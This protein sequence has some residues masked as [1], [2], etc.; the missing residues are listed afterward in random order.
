[1]SEEPQMT[2]SRNVLSAVLP[3][4]AGTLFASGAV[5]NSA[6]GISIG[7][8]NSLTPR[9]RDV[10]CRADPHGLSIFNDAPRR[11]PTGWLYDSPCLP[12]LFKDEAASDTDK[13]DFSI[14]AEV[15]ALVT[16]GDENA[17]LFREFA[18]WSDG[19]LLS[20]FR[21]NAERGRDQFSITAGGIGRDD[22]FGTLSFDRWGSYSVKAFFDKIPH[23][24][25]TNARSPYNGIGTGVLRL[26]PELPPGTNEP[27]DVLAAF[28][29]LQPFTLQ[30]DRERMGLLAEHTAIPNWKFF[31]N[32]LNEDRDGTKPF[33]GGL[34]FSFFPIGSLGVG[35]GMELAEPNRYRTQ[36]F[37][38]GAQKFNGVWQMNVTASGSFFRNEVDTLTFDNPWFLNSLAPPPTGPYVATR[39]RTDLYPDNDSYRIKAEASRAIPW[40]GQFT[41]SVSRG[42]MRQDDAL[43]PFT[44]SSGIGGTAPQ[45]INFDLWNT[46]DALPRRSAEARIATTTAQARLRFSPS[47]PL[48]ISI[49]YRFYDE[50]NKTP[51]FEARNAL[52]GEYGMILMDGVQGSAVPFE[53]PVF[54]PGVPGDPAFHY[55]SIPF[56]TQRQTLETS[57]DY[58]LGRH[59]RASLT[60]T[61][62]QID[63]KF[64]EVA[65]T[66]E[67]RI[68]L[69]WSYRGWE[70]A[71][72]R[73]EGQYASRDGNGY[74]PDPY[75][76]FYSSSLPGATP[77]SPLGFT[78]HALA[79][80][81]KKDV[82]DLRRTK[83]ES[84]LNLM[85][86]DRTDGFLSVQYQEDEYPDSSAGLTGERVTAA[87]AEVNFTPGASFSYF[88][89]ASWQ[90][91]KTSQATINDAGVGLGP[92]PNPGGP[93]FPLENAWSAASEDEDRTVGAGATRSVGPVDLRLN[94]SY[95]NTKTAIDYAYA[96]LGALANPQ[97]GASA[98]SAIPDLTFE[99]AIA[100]L[101]A[102][103]PLSHQ[104][105]ARFYYRYEH[106]RV[107]DWHFDGLTN[108]VNRVMFLG[109]VP[110][111]WDTHTVG[112]FF[113]WQIQ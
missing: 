38:V 85:I 89:F 26:P 75:E 46:V 63:R 91:R 86:N 110:E 105:S 44:I 59:Q 2:L 84:R 102:R 3:V 101:D 57:A 6:V 13:W 79:S 12:T 10:F 50:D 25:G 94:L 90:Q 19:A 60:Y 11:T 9:G 67:D 4:I 111:D 7:Q 56:E 48:A 41:G 87:N 62:E 18:D 43:I 24:W 69:I 88:A 1:M 31:V 45:P 8:G 66:V 49:D 95:V 81:R 23:T 34:F 100:Q 113:Q 35:G 97:L 70:A 82:A 52:T 29:S 5:A 21:L 47:Q 64:R 51:I 36:D 55:R 20:A 58:Q 16:S 17:A 73:L 39:G 40:N 72:L 83:L 32:Y 78:P 80:L 74:N 65:E 106:G 98:G 53:I 104:A 42:S 68:R 103:W 107:Q 61:R 22:A 14:D 92:D 15:G 71:T 108:V 112:V 76:E 30:V 77:A 96:S 28:A 33:S 109:L 99:R 27:A 37:A 54:I 93:T